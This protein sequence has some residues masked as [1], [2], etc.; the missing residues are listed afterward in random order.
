MTGRDQHVVLGF[1]HRMTEIEA[2]MGLVQ[3]TKLDK[4]NEKR[5]TN[6]KYLI[7]ELAKLPWAKIPVLN[8][9]IKHTF[10]WCPLMV[11]ENK[12]G[13]SFEGLKQHLMKN[14]IGYR[15]R[16]QE[17]IYRQKVLRKLGLDFSGLY[18]PNAEAVTGRILGL[19][20]H[21]GLTEQDLIRIVDVL[22]SF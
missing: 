8:R 6:S 2:A 18:L 9:Q 19:P 15:Q 12:A 14:K 11:K 5:I 17:P 21:P 20:N 16:Y 3:L 1:N 13:K 22:N 10:F 4:M 7:K